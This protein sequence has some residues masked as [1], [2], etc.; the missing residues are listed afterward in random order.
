MKVKKELPFNDYKSVLDNA[1]R[2]KIKFTS[3][4]SKKTC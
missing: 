1:N 3:I 2:E 4:R